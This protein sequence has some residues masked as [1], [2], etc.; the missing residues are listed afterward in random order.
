[1]SEPSHEGAAAVSATASDQVEHALLAARDL[2]RTTADDYRRARDRAPRPG[3]A[4]GITAAEDDVR[5]VV[6][7]LVAA[8]ERSVAVILSGNPRQED[9]VCAALGRLPGAPPRERAAD[10][11]RE[12]R[13]A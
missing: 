6:A 4:S 8:A 1:M 9:A 11:A 3:G 7:G 10:R 5:E 2:I 12:A 13:A